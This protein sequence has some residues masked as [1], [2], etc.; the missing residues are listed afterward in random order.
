MVMAFLNK[1][2]KA[3]FYKWSIVRLK[4]NDMWPVN[5]GLITRGVNRC[6]S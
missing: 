1:Q 5:V 2:N 4:N 3:E 6:P